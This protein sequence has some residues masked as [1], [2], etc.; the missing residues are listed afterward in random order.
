MWFLA[1][2]KRDKRKCIRWDEI[3]TESTT[4]SILESKLG[5]AIYQC[6]KIEKIEENDKLGF[7]FTPASGVTIDAL[8]LARRLAASITSI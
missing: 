2:G 7:V 3:L 1:T 8:L 6:D 4:V 5:L